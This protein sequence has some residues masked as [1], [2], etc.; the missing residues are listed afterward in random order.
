[1]VLKPH[2]NSFNFKRMLN[3]V[4]L[5]CTCICT[6]TCTYLPYYSVFF[7]RGVYFANFE[8]MLRFAES[9]SVKLI[10]NHTHVPSVATS[11]VQFS[12]KYIFREIHTP[13]GKYP[14]IYNY[15]IIVL[16][17]GL[18]RQGALRLIAPFSE[19]STPLAD[20]GTP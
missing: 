18:K 11:Q 14:A 17:R 7:S 16:P 13:R 15:S 12:R 4:H 19:S 6:R 3:H 2:H 10:K 9:I 1:M 8:N 20:C 5:K